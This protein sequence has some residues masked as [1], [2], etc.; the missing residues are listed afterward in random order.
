MQIEISAQN[1]EVTD[2][3]REYT[4]GKL[5]RITSHLDT[6]TSIHITFKVEKHQ[7]IAEG[8]VLCP[9]HAVHA[10]ADSETMYKS[11]DLLMDKLVRQITKLKEKMTDHR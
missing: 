10:S 11:V 9:G 4:E 3:L 5:D 8:Q 2:A 1:M 7:Q 6:I